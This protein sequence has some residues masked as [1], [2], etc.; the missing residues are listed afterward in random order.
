M[1]LKRFLVVEQVDDH[2]SNGDDSLVNCRGS[3]GDPAIVR[4][5]GYVK[6][7]RSMVNLI[8]TDDGEPVLPLAAVRRNRRFPG[9]RGQREDVCLVPWSSNGVHQLEPVTGIGSMYVAV[10]RRFLPGRDQ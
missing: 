3:P 4:A 2:R 10:E 1:V 6:K 7:T 9:L 5:A 8:R